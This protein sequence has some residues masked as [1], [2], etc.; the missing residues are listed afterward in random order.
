MRIAVALRSGPN[1]TN[2]RSECLIPAL[3]ALGHRVDRIDRGEVVKGADLLIQTGFAGSNALRSQIDNELPYLIMEA[4]FWRDFYD[5]HEASS[6]GYNG[7]AGG[8]YAP[9]APN[10]E[11][12][13]PPLK[14]M[15]AGAGPTIII[16]QKPTD[17]SLRG[18]NHVEWIRSVRAEI[19]SADFRPHPLMVPSDTLE[20]IATVLE[21]YV[22]V[23]TYTSTVGCE[24]LVA[25]CQVRADHGSNLTCGVT[26][27]YRADWHHG[28][29][30][31]QS[32][33]DTFGELVPHILSGYDEARS[34]ARLGVVE[35]PRE[36]VRDK[37]IE[38]EYYKLIKGN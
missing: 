11:R 18:S 14:P 37:R 32:T 29:S 10:D 4:P 5:V 15:K 33:H 22:Q 28:L 17:H 35:E 23:V 6:W 34:R 24:A 7:L 12:P 8:A 19:P 21:R 26:D 2:P 20:P 38:Q 13:R 3:E 30:W 1:L 36:R 9:Q 25:G 16:G 31:R 27:E